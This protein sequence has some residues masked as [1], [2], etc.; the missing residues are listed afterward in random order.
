MK[1]LPITKERSSLLYSEKD[2][3]LFF[4]FTVSIPRPEPPVTFVRLPVIRGV[5]PCSLS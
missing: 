3:V 4:S 1:R 5:V 2:A